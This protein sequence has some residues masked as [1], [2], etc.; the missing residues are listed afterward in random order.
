VQRP[1]GIIYCSELRSLLAFRPGDL[2][3]SD[4]A[5]MQ[6]L[7][8]GYVPDPNSVFE[9]VCKLRPGH[10]LL[11]SKNSKLEVRR[12]WQPGEPEPV[13]ETE[14]ALVETL[15][16]KL[17]GAVASHLESEV[18]LG[19]FLSGGLD[20]STV[21]ALM[22]R[23]A[24]GRIKTFSIGFAEAEYD[25][26]AAA[27]AVATAFGTEHTE[28]IVKPDV[29]EIFESIA[30]M[31]DEPFG[32][33]SAIPTFLVAQ[34][35]R[36][37]VTVALSGDGG[38]ELFGGYTRYRDSMQQF[39]LPA[40]LGT[41]AATIGRWLPHATLGRN[42]LID[43]GRS[44]WGR[45]ATHVLQPVR[46]DEGG[47]AAANQ[48]GA[49]RPVAEQ[50]GAYL[51]EAVGADFAAS[52]MRLDML[53]YLPGDILTKVDRTSMAVSLEARVPLLDAGLVDFSL[54]LPGHLRASKMT[55]KYLFR[56]AIRGLVPDFVL[57]GPKKGFAVP[58]GPW[59]RGP[60]RHH[61]ESL[62]DPGGSLEPYVDRAAVRR[63]A[64]EHLARRRDHGAMLWRLIVLERWFGALANGQLAR[65]P[66]VPRL[67]LS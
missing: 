16:A 19:A 62:R 44:D 7:A 21:V 46:L 51:S 22:S 25:E 42:R 31:F 58:L 10:L 65:S 14:A 11:W 47:V 2:R 39:S 41:L 35:A 20:S 5:I 54:S 23:Q 30:A 9:G 36:Q 49:S 52:M 66:S 64:G 8:F 33:S 63:V 34:L 45:Y 61:V 32:D 50:F 18:P 55:G 13:T 27:R 29:E 67:R 17:Y 38:D 4:A 43:L 48:P 24:P 37:T 56:Q 6:Y 59:F 53:T 28:L 3:I 12:Y 60:L 1:E 40:P 15:K 57:D 26:S